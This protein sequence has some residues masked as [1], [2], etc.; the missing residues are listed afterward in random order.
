LRDGPLV[1]LKPSFCRLEGVERD[2][3]REAW[4]ASVPCRRPLVACVI[5]L[6]EDIENV[7]L[8][9]AKKLP[10]HTEVEVLLL[11]RIWGANPALFLAKPV[12][13]HSLLREDLNW[14][15]HAQVTIV[16]KR[17]PCLAYWGVFM[18][19]QVT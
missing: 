10:T 16:E 1:A 14:P 13:R 3:T 12:R 2:L 4:M 9:N 8:G 11:V 7:H 15:M 19:K 18:C 6:H 5:A 17:W